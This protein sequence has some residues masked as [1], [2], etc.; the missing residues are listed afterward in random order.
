MKRRHGRPFQ[1]RF[2]PAG[3]LADICRRC[4]T[5]FLLAGGRGA[6]DEME[7]GCP[8]F[9]GTAAK[10]WSAKMGLSPSETVKLFFPKPL[11]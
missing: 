6:A 2:R 5:G 7:G 4:V 11:A 10:P 1:S 9:P 3:C 8:D